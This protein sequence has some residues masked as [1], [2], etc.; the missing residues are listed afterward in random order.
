MKKLII[1]AAMLAMITSVY[2]QIQPELNQISY[3]AA[4]ITGMEPAGNIVFTAHKQAIHKKHS[5][6][7]PL[8]SKAI[9]SF[10]AEENNKEEIVAAPSIH[11]AEFIPEN[12]GVNCNA[13]DETT[14]KVK[15]NLTILKT[16]K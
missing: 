1:I 4:G 5:H 11:S 3:K 16:R 12:G 14:Y 6:K 10:A 8:K 13:F 7:N 9:L 15:A 2:A